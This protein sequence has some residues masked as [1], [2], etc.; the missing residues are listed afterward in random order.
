MLAKLFAPTDVGAAGDFHI[1]KEPRIDVTEKS[2]LQR[3]HTETR[4][5]H[6]HLLPG[7]Q[8]LTF[9][10]MQ[11]AIKESSLYFMGAVDDDDARVCHALQ[12]GDK[13][14]SSITNA[15]VIF[16]VAARNHFSLSQRAFTNVRKSFR[17]AAAMMS[18][19]RSDSDSSLF[20][21]RFRGKFDH[22]TFLRCHANDTHTHTPAACDQFAASCSFG[23]TNFVDGST[24]S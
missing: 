8:T 24:R 6:V 5:A 2:Y 1:W 9:Y 4:H 18:F 7:H 14:F 21:L 13:P 15:R 3:A 19:Q 12:P 22:R 17:R 11:K 23:M 10:F 16:T 20:V